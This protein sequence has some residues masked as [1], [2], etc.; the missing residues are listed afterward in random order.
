MR[1]TTQCKI[2]DTMRSGRYEGG[3]ECNTINLTPT[4]GSDSHGWEA[5]TRP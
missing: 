3:E 4:G 5:I 2:L 1:D